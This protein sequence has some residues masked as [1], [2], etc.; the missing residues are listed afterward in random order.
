MPK[1]TVTKR[2]K[3]ART[4]TNSQLLN[5]MKNSM[6]P[7]FEHFEI[8][9]AETGGSAELHITVTAD[10]GNVKLSYGF[11]HIANDKSPDESAKEK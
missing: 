5:A 3:T 4:V 11:A 2:Y 8:V 10:A 7:I 6:R 1:S 9:I